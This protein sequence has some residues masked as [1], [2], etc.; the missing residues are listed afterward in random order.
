MT[1]VRL[2][3]TI[4]NAPK[5]VVKIYRLIEPITYAVPQRVV[6]TKI[7]PTRPKDL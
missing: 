1:E 5:V 3:S 7:S 2:K 6:R 4:R